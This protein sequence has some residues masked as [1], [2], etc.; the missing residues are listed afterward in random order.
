MCLNAGTSVIRNSTFSLTPNPSS[1][2]LVGGNFTGDEIRMFNTITANVSMNMNYYG[3]GISAMNMNYFRLNNSS[4][5]Q[6]NYGGFGGVIYLTVTAATRIPTPSLPVYVIDSC[7]FESN[8]AHFGGA[9]YLDDV[10]YAMISSC[11]FL[12]NSVVTTDSKG[13]YGGA[14]YFF[15]SGTF[16]SD[17]F[18]TLF[19]VSL[20]DR[21]HVQPKFGI[22]R[23]RS[24]LLELQPAIEHHAPGIY[25]EFSNQVRSKLRVIRSSSEIH[26]RI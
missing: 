2:Y 7:S 18:R 25:A 21:K 11:K 14:I 4:F 16:Q 6:L 3:S 1:I 15:T 24:D 9:V 20:R 8:S 10:D 22:G 17:Y 5:K 12:N 26:I 23:R 13:G 19:K